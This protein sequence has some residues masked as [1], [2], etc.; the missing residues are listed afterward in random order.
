MGPRLTT[1]WT[2]HRVESPGEEQKI[3]R[4]RS[5]KCLQLRKARAL[6]SE[7]RKVER[8]PYKGLA[9]TH[10]SQTAHPLGD[11][12]SQ[13]I[14]ILSQMRQLRARTAVLGGVPPRDGNSR[15]RLHHRATVK[16]NQR[17]KGGYLA[18]ATGRHSQPLHGGS[19]GKPRYRAGECKPSIFSESSTGSVLV[20]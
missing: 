2:C 16:S 6:N 12:L 14:T 15:G 1:R 10:Q 18:S 4:T 20:W 7:G 8:H 9:P 17:V 19:R 13:R 5:W 11:T 3:V